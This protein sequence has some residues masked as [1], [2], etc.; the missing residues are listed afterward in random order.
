MKTVL[1]FM[2]A[3]LAL[4][5]AATEYLSLRSAQAELFPA[6]THFREQK[7][8]LS[9]AELDVVLAEAGS[10]MRGLRWRQWQAWR[11]DEL[12]GHVLSDAVIGKH[13]L[14]DYAVAFDRA[15]RVQGVRVLTYRETQGGEVR[16]LP[17]LAQFDG[18]SAGSPLR[19]GQGIDNISGATLSCKHLTDGIRRL[20][21]YVRRHLQGEE[22]T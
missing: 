12:L 4:P 13:E 21:F 9:R 7:I 20:A 2:L 17:W 15:G 18:L 22:G 16:A 3:V 14:F 5:S 6:A 10:S 19:V 8:S 11:G 1:F